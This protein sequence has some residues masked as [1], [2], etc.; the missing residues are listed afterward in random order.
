MCPLRDIV[1][2]A[3]DDGT[4][5][6]TEKDSGFQAIDGVVVDID[7]VSD[8]GGHLA[9][10]DGL[11]VAGDDFGNGD[12]VASFHHTSGDTGSV[13]HR[14]LGTDKEQ[15]DKETRLFGSADEVQLVVGR[16]NCLENHA[17]PVGQA[18][19]APVGTVFGSLS[20]RLGR[21]PVAETLLRHLV[22]VD[23]N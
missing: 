9:V 7:T 12:I 14:R 22:G 13:N 6:K 16:E 20:H 1:C 17:L 10:D 2:I 21:V 11:L 18:A 3:F 4:I 5:S 23:I 15:T 19:F 8:A